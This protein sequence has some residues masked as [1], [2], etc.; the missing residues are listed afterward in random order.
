MTPIL[1]VFVLVFI[2][3][4]IWFGCRIEP[5]AGEIAVL[6]KK[7]GEDLPSGQILALKPEQKGIQLD[8]L[9][10]GRTF[11]NPYAWAWSYW[12]ITDIPAGKL[13]V[14]TR[15]YGDD[16]P[17]GEIIAHEN[18]KGIV[19]EVLTP[20][21]YR[22]NP[23]AFNVK[24]SD[25]VNIHPGCVGVKVSLVGRD[26]LND[27]NIPAEQRNTFLVA[28]GMKGAQEDVLNPGTYY[29]NPFMY[30][31]VE[32][33]LQSQRFAV[34]GDGAINFLTMDGFTV[35]VE[36]TI[37]FAIQREKAAFLTHRVGDMN[38]I[39]Q[40]LIVPRMRGFCR[41]E[42]SKHPAI[43]FIVGQTRQQFQTDL[44]KHLRSN[45]DE[46][47]VS[48]KS[49]LIRNIIPPD[50]IASII[51][52]RQVAVQESLKY[53]Q[54]I[55]QAISKAELVKQETLAQQ[56]K[57]KVEADTVRIRAVINADQEQDVRIIAANKDMDVAKVENEAAVA[58]AKAILFKAQ[59][60]ADVIRMQNIAQAGVIKNQVK[61]F[62]TG[63][64]FA[65]YTFY[66]KIGPDIES[67]LTSDQEQGLGTLFLPFLPQGKELK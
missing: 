25:A 58:Q 14:K 4:F 5:K 3:L 29:L 28:D 32:V 31:V 45:C 43:N 8:V 15:L 12:P 48:I 24:M 11:R 60:D 53:D 66:T 47:G 61:A 64:N 19:A 21:R 17:S 9:A 65:R 23:Y 57:E 55:K 1:V 67:I 62:S 10:E 44:E 52:D 50:Q 35:V 22:I 6:I 20:G 63:Q 37:E 7:T 27:K 42:G 36:G 56:N 59:A 49:V 2:P 34:S 30:D 33:N 41:I 54:E 18:T 13:G 16:L 38:D 51:R 26:I 39:V 40:K 46:W